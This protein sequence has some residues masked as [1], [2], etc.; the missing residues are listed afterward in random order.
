MVHIIGMNCIK[1]EIMHHLQF[2]TYFYDTNA[3]I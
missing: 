3:D 1:L 2:L